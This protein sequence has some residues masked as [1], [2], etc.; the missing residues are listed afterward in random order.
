MEG[1]WMMKKW[2]LAL[3][4]ALLLM[5]VILVNLLLKMKSLHLQNKMFINIR[6]CYCLLIRKLFNKMVFSFQI[7]LNGVGIGDFAVF[8][9][10]SHH[11]ATCI[12]SSQKDC[13]LTFTFEEDCVIVKA[14]KEDD[15][16]GA[17]LS[18]HYVLQEA[19]S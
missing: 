15:F 14:T 6:I 10:Q 7:E 2:G 8:T 11:Q 16:L 13:Q 1:A 17:D 12:L 3:I 19:L 5:D 18:G 9:D 4:C